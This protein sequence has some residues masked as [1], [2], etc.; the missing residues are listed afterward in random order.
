MSDE[1]GFSLE[2]KR[3]VARIILR[4]LVLVLIG[5]GVRQPAFLFASW[6]A[7]PVALLESWARRRGRAGIGLAVGVFVV[8]TAVFFSAVIQAIYATAMLRSRS[9]GFALLTVEADLTLLFVGRLP[10]IVPVMFFVQS[11]ALACTFDALACAT[12]A[13]SG[14]PGAIVGLGSWTILVGFVPAIDWVILDAIQDTQGEL[15][16]KIVISTFALAV[17]SAVMTAGLFSTAALA[18]RLVGAPSE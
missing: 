15:A 1:Q 17:G 2:K 8:A 4:A 18:D 5:L 3:L 6:V 10:P 14:L 12:N 13:R 16:S 11:A 9:I 7:V